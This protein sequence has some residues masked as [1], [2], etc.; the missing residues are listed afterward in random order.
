VPS[1]LTT[2]KVTPKDPISPSANVTVAL[3]LSEPVVYLF[4]ALALA[5]HAK[6]PTAPSP[7]D[8]CKKWIMD[9]GASCT[10][11]CNCSWFDQ[12]FP[13]S[14]SIDIT[15]GDSS[16]V[17][18]IGIEW[19]HTCMWDGDKWIDTILQEVLFIPDLHGNLLSVAQLTS[20]SAGIYFKDN[21]CEILQQ[22]LVTCQGMCKSGLYIMHMHTPQVATAYIATTKDLPSEESEH[23]NAIPTMLPTSKA[24]LG[25]WHCWL[26]HLHSNAILQMVHKGMV[27]GIKIHGEPTMAKICKPCIAGKQTHTEIHKVL[28]TCTKE[29]LGHIFSDLCRPLPTISHQGY[30]YFATFIDDHS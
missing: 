15:L 20:H 22:G 12:Y 19:V 11:C 3:S 10:M 2:P 13:L 4:M 8:V 28:E 6:E 7:T 18:V 30:Q 27:K 21:H 16:L 14:P 24:T 9:S 5:R 17:P 26:G 1:A 29:P 25:T 23:A